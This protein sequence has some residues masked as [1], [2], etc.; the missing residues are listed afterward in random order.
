M[1]HPAIENHCSIRSCNH[2]CTSFLIHFEVVFM[3]MTG[4][5]SEHEHLEPRLSKRQ[6]SRTLHG[7]AYCSVMSCIWARSHGKSSSPA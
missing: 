4:L 2:A 6:P 3:Q 1:L 7:N 5:S